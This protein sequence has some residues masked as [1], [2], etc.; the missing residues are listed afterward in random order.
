ME[1]PVV[2]LDT[3]IYN[4]KM[5]S[6][7]LIIENDALKVMARYSLDVDFTTLNILKLDFFPWS[8]NSL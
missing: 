1:T 2:V 6:S 3:Q 7:I 5:K 4:I 8:L